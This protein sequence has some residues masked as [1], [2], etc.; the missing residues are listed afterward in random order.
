L[1]QHESTAAQQLRATTSVELVDL[2]RIKPFTVNSMLWLNFKPTC[3]ISAKP[4]PA[5][6]KIRRWSLVPQTVS[7]YSHMAD[8]GKTSRNLLLS[9]RLSTLAPLTP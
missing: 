3:I 1:A 2:Y 7:A 4:T 5:I 6:R 9:I 8:A